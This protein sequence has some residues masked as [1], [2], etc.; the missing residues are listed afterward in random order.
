M[1]HII[2]ARPKPGRAETPP[3]PPDFEN[4]LST[5]DLVDDWPVAGDG[6]GSLKPQILATCIACIGAFGLGT[7][8]GWS[9]PALPS[10][11]M[12]GGLGGSLLTKSDESWVGSLVNVSQSSH[13]NANVKG[14]GSITIAQGQTKS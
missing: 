5:S 3:L 13:A 8:I 12:G 11:K 1:P 4:S 10:I 2:S 14:Q 6:R 9:A 7:V